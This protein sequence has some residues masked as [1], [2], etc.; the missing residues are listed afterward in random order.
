[1]STYGIYWPW[2]HE[3]IWHIQGSFSVGYRFYTHRLWHAYFTCFQLYVILCVFVYIM[4]TCEYAPISSYSACYCCL[5]RALKYTLLYHVVTAVL[6]CVSSL[7]SHVV[8]AV[9]CSVSSQL[10]C[11]LCRHWCAVFCVVTA[12][13]SQLI[14]FI[15]SLPLTA[16]MKTGL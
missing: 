13:L 10:C 15:E 6:C 9:P 3:T 16:L 4:C 8:T 7:L 12:G 11:V 1:M 2:N 5:H 14:V